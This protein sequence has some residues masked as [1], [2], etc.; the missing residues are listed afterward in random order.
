MPGD[1]LWGHFLVCGGGNEGRYD[2]PE[3]VDYFGGPPVARRAYERSDGVHKTFRLRL[4]PSYPENLFRFGR[5]E[6]L[7][8]A[9]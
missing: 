1:R 3:Q 2:V 4:W 6:R 7:A 5:L 8:F 9:D